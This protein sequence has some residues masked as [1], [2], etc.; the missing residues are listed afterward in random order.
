MPEDM[1]TAPEVEVLRMLNGDSNGEWGAWVAAC[2][3]WLSGHG[4][5]TDS[6]NYQITDKGKQFLAT[7][8]RA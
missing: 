8:G 6:P 1:P 7:G 3:E 5:C 4:Y 2:L